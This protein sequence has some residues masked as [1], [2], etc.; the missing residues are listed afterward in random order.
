M[1]NPVHTARVN[2]ENKYL[3]REY[4]GPSETRFIMFTC[5]TGFRLTG[6]RDPEKNM[7]WFSKYSVFV[8]GESLF[9][10]NFM[11]DSLCV[12]LVLLGQIVFL[13]P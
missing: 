2:F 13:R 12:Q 7:Y 3:Q 6:Y 1:Y 11:C 8:H 5:D 4:A 10:V 9:E